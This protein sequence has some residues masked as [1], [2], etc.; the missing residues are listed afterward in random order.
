MTL[1]SIR[2]MSNQ[3]RESFLSSTYGRTHRTGRLDQL[4]HLTLRRVCSQGSQDL[5]DL[6]DL[7]KGVFTN[8]TL[9][10]HIYCLQSELFKYPGC[11]MVYLISGETTKST[12]CSAL[13]SQDRD[14]EEGWKK[15][16]IF[17][18]F[19]S[20]SFKTVEW[21]FWNKKKNSLFKCVVLTNF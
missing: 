6:I 17:G 9:V 3:T 2:L 7:K 20:F 15:I 21:E 14:E 11:P 1:G 5:T 16:H 4:L 8:R 19:S 10:T 12:K 13:Q 18:N